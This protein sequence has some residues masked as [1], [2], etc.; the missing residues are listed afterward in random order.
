M[1]CPARGNGKTELFK[2]VL[3]FVGCFVEVST[4]AAIASTF[5]PAPPIQGKNRKGVNRD[6]E[7][8]KD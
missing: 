4:E 2:V 6:M 1:G 3:P 7:L 8:S 5:S